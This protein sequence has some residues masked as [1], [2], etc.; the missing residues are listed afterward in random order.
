MDWRL[1][2]VIVPVGD[3]DRAKEFYSERVGFHVDLDHQ[4]SDDVRIV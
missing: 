3:V 2:V 4:V 1:E